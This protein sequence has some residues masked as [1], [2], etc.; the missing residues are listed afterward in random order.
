MKNELEIVAI[1]LTPEEQSQLSKRIVSF[2]KQGT[3]VCDVVDILNVSIRHVQPRWKK[4]REGGIATI[5][6]KV[7]ERKKEPIVA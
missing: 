3:P 6:L 5:G 7:M 2:C 4:Y 1:E